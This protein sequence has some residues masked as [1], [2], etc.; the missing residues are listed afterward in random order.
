MPG[1]GVDGMPGMADAVFGTMFGLLVTGVV[2]KSSSE[3][4]EHP[5]QQLPQE[6]KVN[7]SKDITKKLKTFIFI[8]SPFF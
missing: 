6:A 7:K 1:A 4:V 5:L 2:L 3:E 8:N